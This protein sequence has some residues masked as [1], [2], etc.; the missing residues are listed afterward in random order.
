MFLKEK[1][2]GRVKG[3]ACANGSKKRTYINKEGDTSPTVFTEAVFLTALIE[4]YEEMDVACFEI[5]GA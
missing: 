2:D 5:P 3:I 4:S 1:R